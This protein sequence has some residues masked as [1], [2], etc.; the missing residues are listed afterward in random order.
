VAVA[1]VRAVSVARVVPVVV[2]GHCVGGDANQLGRAL[3][4]STHASGNACGSRC[5]NASGTACVPRRGIHTLASDKPKKEVQLVVDICALP[6][7][8]QDSRIFGYFSRT[9]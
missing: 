1:R 7:E 3:I 8:P 9:L 2:V 4:Y 5:S 6:G